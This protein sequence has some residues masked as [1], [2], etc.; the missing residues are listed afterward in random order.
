MKTNKK[1]LQM[2]LSI[3][4]WQGLADALKT[5]NWKEEAL[6]VLR[7]LSCRLKIY[8]LF[9]NHINNYFYFG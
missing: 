7:R 5:L 4:I 6:V 8:S 2:A 3:F 9:F 1:P